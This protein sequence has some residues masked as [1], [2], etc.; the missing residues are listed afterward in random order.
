[1]NA[2]RPSQDLGTNKVIPSLYNQSRC[3]YCNQPV[4]KGIMV[5]AL[6]KKWHAG[7]FTCVKCGDRLDK[8]EFFEK[9]GKPYCGLDYHTLFNSR[10][11]YCKEPIEG[12]SVQALGKHYHEG[13][14]FCHACKTPFVEQQFMIHDGH[15]YCEKDYLEKFGHRCQG[16]GNYIKGSFV[17]ALG[18]DW[19]KECFVCADCGKPFP[20]GTFHVRDNRP[21]CEQHAKTSSNNSNI[22]DKNKC[23]VCKESLAG[24]KLI[25]SAFGNNYHPQH[26]QCTSCQRPL[27]ARVPGNTELKKK[28][29]SFL[30]V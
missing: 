5:S 19:H 1:M 30:F 14:F 6:G 7:C 3:G 24:A 26:F 2:T 8:V 20:S 21:Y 18:G 12:T 23:Y 13:H 17:G 15:A 28:K 11:D 22:S 4:S 10:C 9:D 16:C 25:A 29:E 27:S